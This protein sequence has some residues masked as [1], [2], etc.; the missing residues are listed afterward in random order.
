MNVESGGF[1]DLLSKH[2]KLDMKNNFLHI[3]LDLPENLGLE[4]GINRLGTY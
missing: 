1:Y 2:D 4:T 3:E